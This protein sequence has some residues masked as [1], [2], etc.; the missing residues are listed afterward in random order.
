MGRGSNWC[1]GDIFSRRDIPLSP[2]CFFH[3]IDCFMSIMSARR[4][5][6]ERA[7]RRMKQGRSRP[8]AHPRS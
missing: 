3:V 6:A 5:T 7:G 1:G 8:T 2:S 4:V